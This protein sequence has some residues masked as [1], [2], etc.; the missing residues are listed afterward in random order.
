[1]LI[2]KVGQNEI[3]EEL[4]ETDIQKFFYTFKH[5]K[6]WSSFFFLL[7]ISDFIGQIV[8]FFLRLVA[9]VGGSNNFIR[10]FLSRRDQRTGSG[11][12]PWNLSMGIEDLEN[13]FKSF[14]C[15]FLVL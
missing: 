5:I 15:A 2:V 8:K 9:P 4:E 11:F 3:K 12:L 6:H 10:Y 14:L 13:L 7:V 1:M